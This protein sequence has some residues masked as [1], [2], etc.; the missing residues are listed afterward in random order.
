MAIFLEFFV[1]VSL[2]L[3]G[4]ANCGAPP[5]NAFLHKSDGAEPGLGIP[6]M[7]TIQTRVKRRLQRWR[8]TLPTKWRQM[9]ANRSPKPFQRSTWMLG[10]VRYASSRRSNE[11]GF[12]LETKGA[13]CHDG[14]MLPCA[15]RVFSSVKKGAEKLKNHC[16]ATCTSSPIINIKEFGWRKEET[17]NTMHPKSLLAAHHRAA[18]TTRE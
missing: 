12:I 9:Q 18:A 1:P 14:V 15:T 4:T 11:E 2:E 13:A 17:G 10:I 6:A 3:S 16:K 5:L 8:A 7:Q